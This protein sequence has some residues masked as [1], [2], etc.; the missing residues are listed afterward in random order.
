MRNPGCFHVHPRMK[1]TIVVD[2]HLWF[3]ANEEDLFT[4]LHNEGIGQYNHAIDRIYLYSDAQVTY[5]TLRWG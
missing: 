2:S 3:I 5:F 1:W 4:W